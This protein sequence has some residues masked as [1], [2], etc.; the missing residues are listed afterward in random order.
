[1]LEVTNEPS[2]TAKLRNKL[3]KIEGLVLKWQTKYIQ[4]DALE[5]IFLQLA[6]AEEKGYWGAA[7][8]LQKLLN[9]A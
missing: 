9:E 7:E 5:P 6:T 3:E 1:M 8:D 4:P 2:E